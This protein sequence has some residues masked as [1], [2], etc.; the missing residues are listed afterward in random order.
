MD[1]VTD[2]SLMAATKALPD[3]WKIEPFGGKFFKRWH[4]RIYDTLDVMNL[5][6]FLTEPPPDSDSEN[7]EVLLQNWIKANKV[8]RSTILSTLSNELYDVYSQHK[9]AYE[10]WAQLRKKYIIEDAGAQSMSLLI[11]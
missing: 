9:F 3:T 2:A 6:E 7:Y 4:D 8:C 1:A 11:F 10:I 5:A